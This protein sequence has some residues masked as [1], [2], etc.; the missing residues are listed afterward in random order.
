LA[1][2]KG[3]INNIKPV[4]E[5]IKATIFYTSADLELQALIQAKE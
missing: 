3:I 2:Q 1:K 5:K 4:L